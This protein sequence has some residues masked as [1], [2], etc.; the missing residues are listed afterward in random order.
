M[1]LPGSVARRAVAV[2]ASAALAAALVS[3]TAA[4]ALAGGP[5]SDSSGTYANGEYAST[6]TSQNVPS[7][8]DDSIKAAPYSGAYDGE[9]HAIALSGAAGGST[10]QYR[11]SP[12]GAWST[13]APTRTNVGTTTVYWQVTNPNY[14]TASGTSSITITPTATKVSSLT[15]ASSGITVKWAKNSTGEGYKIYRSK[16]GGTYI[17]ITTISGNE[18]T[19][20]TD[21][22][23]KTNGAKYS[24]RVVAY[25]SSLEGGYSTTLTTYRLAQP[26]IKA[27]SC[28]N[29]KTMTAKWGTNTKATGYQV[30]YSLNRAMSNA[31]TKTYSGTNKVSKSIG[32]LTKGKTY[33]VQVRSIKKVGNMDYYSAWSAVKKVSITK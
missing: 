13:T 8:N 28:S 11:T 31:K 5:S 33:Y 32:S 23:A 18:N 19:S 25:S 20:F 2:F 6:A 12:T 29:A 30:R 1:R 10:V 16:D 21:D 15:N 17:L 7:A 22:D 3:A 4:C 14:N 26:A 24:Y 27:L 9:A